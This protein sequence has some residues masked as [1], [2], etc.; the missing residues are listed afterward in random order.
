M[1]YYEIPEANKNSTLVALKTTPYEEEKVFVHDENLKD[2]EGLIDFLRVATLK[3][4]T[5][6][7]EESYLSI[8]GT[9]INS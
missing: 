3:A 1:Y 5:T 6:L 2:K 4:V 9:P 8:F 7:N